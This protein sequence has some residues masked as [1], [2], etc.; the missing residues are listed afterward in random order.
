MGKVD[1]DEKTLTDLS[2]SN[3]MVKAMFETSAPKYKFGGSG[4]INKIYEIEPPR[5][6]V[7]P[8]NSHDNRKWV[9]DSINKYFDVI[10]EEED[11]DEEEDDVDDD[12]ESEYENSSEHE[13]PAPARDEAK[14]SFKSSLRMRGL[15]SSVASKLTGSVSNLSAGD[16]VQTLKKNL[17]SQINLRA[18][19]KDLSQT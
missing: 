2:A 19:N 16:V 17:G 7:T 14:S 5:K 13:E 1:L 8:P 12:D 18:S 9:L 10:A 11:D 3:R 6:K 4:I 15:L